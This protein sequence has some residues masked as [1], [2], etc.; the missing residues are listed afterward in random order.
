[1]TLKEYT[2]HDNFP[3]EC[4]QTSIL[5]KFRAY[6]VFQLD[7]F[8]PCPTFTAAILFV[9]CEQR[10]CLSLP[11]CKSRPHCLNTYG[12]SSFFLLPRS[13]H[14]YVCVA[15]VTPLHVLDKKMKQY[16]FPFFLFFFLFF[17]LTLACLTKHYLIYL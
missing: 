11:F 13:V 6:M 17:V 4:T 12:A 3:S 10:G 8:Y 7:C 9:S 2:R 14:S 15:E 5:R 16:P 1:M